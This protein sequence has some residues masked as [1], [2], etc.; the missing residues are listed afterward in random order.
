[1]LIYIDVNIEKVPD[2]SRRMLY[3]RCRQV[4]FPEPNI[5]RYIFFNKEIRD[6]AAAELEVRNV[7]FK[8]S[9]E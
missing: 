4:I 3:D 2:D 1:M 9:E 5:Y 8:K 7:E 6:I